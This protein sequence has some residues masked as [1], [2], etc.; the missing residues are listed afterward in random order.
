MKKG[1]IVLIAVLVILI[2]FVGKIIGVYNGLVELDENTNAAWAQ[3]NNQYQRRADLIPNL[4]NTVKGYAAHE[5]E[6][7]E[8]VTNARA[9]V[10]QMTITPEILNNPQAFKQFQAA[11]SEISSALS[12]LMVVSERYPELKANQNFMALQDQLEGTENRIAV[13]RKRFNEMIQV[14]NKRIRRFPT[15]MIAGMLGFERKYYFEAETGAEQAPEVQ[16]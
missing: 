6:T 11:Q 16:F 5:K 3:V 7:F 10:G 15:S 9:K 12:R 8:A 4:V 2:L 1:W 14:Y 13:E